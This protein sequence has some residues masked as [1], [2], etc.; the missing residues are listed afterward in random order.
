MNKLIKGDEVRVLA[1]KDRDKT[2]TVEVVNRTTG[3]VMIMG[4]NM[5]KRHVRAMNGVEGGIIEIPKS[6]AISNVA[7][8]CPNCGKASRVG[9]Q[10]GKDGKKIRICK[11]CGK[12]IAVKEKKEGKK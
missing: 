5:S 4:V 6:I 8:V 11:K 7:L 2:G 10:E 3:R 9:I 1:G 12:D